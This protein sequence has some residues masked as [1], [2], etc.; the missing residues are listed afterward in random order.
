MKRVVKAGIAVLILAALSLTG[1][2]CAQGEEAEMITETEIIDVQRGDLEI[3]ITAVGNLALAVEEDLAFEVGGTISEI[4]VE[5]GDTVKEGQLIASLDIAER[6]DLLETLGNALTNAEK[7]VTISRRDLIQAEINL[8]NAEIALE[9]TSTTYS[10]QDFKVAQA[11]VDE[12]QRNLDETV[13]K[14]DRYEVGSTGYEAYQDI[15]R[16]AQARLTTA[17]N[18]LD[19]MISGFEESDVAVKRLQ[20][21]ISQGK[22]D[23]ALLTVEEAE[24]AV[25][26]ARIKLNEAEDESSVITA[27]FD[28]FITSVN[29][30]SGDTV[31]K[32]RVAVVISDPT[33]FEADIFVNENDIFQITTGGRAS[34]QVDAA[35]MVTIPATVT[36]ISPTAT[37]QSGIVNYMVR[38]ELE[39]FDH[40]M[41][42]EMPVRAQMPDLTSGEM[43]ERLQQAIDSGR[44]TEEEAEEM[45]ERI[46][47]GETPFRQGNAE[48]GMPGVDA[49]QLQQA[50]DSGRITQEQADEMLDRMKSDEMPFGEGSISGGQLTDTMPM[51]FQLRQGLSVT[52]SIIVDERSDVLLVPNAAIT[53]RGGQA[54]VQIPSSDGTTEERAI[55]TGIADWQFTEVLSG[56]TDGEQ[57]A[58]IRTIS[59]SSTTESSQSG[60]TMRIPGMGGGR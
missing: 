27:P 47:S 53:S 22:Y 45:M 13:I 43:P 35:Q 41:Q 59:S 10:V 51:N 37:I 38:V 12:A 18:K 3:E 5:A 15:V 16:Q 56:I 49:E 54:Y 19:S 30:N 2:G 20:M 23:A 25:T 4:L 60:A 24:Q 9:E 42:G 17:E 48:G 39:S 58:I 21:E 33:K 31:K 32:G 8:L 46:K 7:Q 14:L 44:I 52:V 55:Q 26:D 1:L 50:V 11:D 36:H 57:V 34:V 6:D 40:S 29:V 28:G